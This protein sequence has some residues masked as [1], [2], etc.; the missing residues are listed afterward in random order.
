MKKNSIRRFYPVRERSKASTKVEIKALKRR[1]SLGQ[2]V[3]EFALVAPLLLLTIFGIIDIAR[4]IQ[5][6]VTVNNAARQ[7]IR[8]AVT[9]QTLKDAGGNY[10]PRAQSITDLAVASLAGLPLTN[11]DDPLL[12]GFNRVRITSSN[13]DEGDP[14]Q[15]N[16][17]V[18]IEVVYTVKP[19]TPLVSAIIPGIELKGVEMAINE[20]WGA[21]Q[22]FD[23]GNLG[24]TPL[25]LAT[26]TP[27]PYYTQTAIAQT[28]TAS[29][30]QTAVAQMT[31]VAQTATAG[32]L[33]TQTAVARATQTANAQSTQT[34]V[35]ATQTAQA[36]TFT[37]TKTP[38]ITLTPTITPTATNTSTKTPT[39]TITLTPTITP[40]ATNTVPVTATRTS[41][42]T[43]T[44]TI[45]P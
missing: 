37:P 16:E 22:S 18:R 45:T 6:Q 24:P 14:G 27:V 30:Q 4:I 34:S 23:H 29:F 12:W 41:T 10:I 9:G 1:K 26:W 28:A 8:F 20:E 7:A 44:P 2:G 13:G 19:L 42:K 39:P 33:V 15:P 38:T 3:V 40:T 35:A 17:V 5:A 21:V 32:P 36:P 25:P 31:S 43:P 11:T